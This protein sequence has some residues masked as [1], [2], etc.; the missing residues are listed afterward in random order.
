MEVNLY[1]PTACRVTRAGKDLKKRKLLQKLKRLGN[2]RQQHCIACPE[3]RSFAT[4]KR[5]WKMPQ[6]KTYFPTK[7]SIHIDHLYTQLVN[8]VIYRDFHQ[9]MKLIVGSNDPRPHQNSLA[10]VKSCLASRHGH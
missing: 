1:I 3:N 7:S 2:I 10:H 9:R 6:N 5:V 4:V 8:N